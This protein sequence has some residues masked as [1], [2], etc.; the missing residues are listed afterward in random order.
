LV[1]GEE[2]SGR[3]YP[4]PGGCLEGAG[5]GYEEAAADFAKALRGNKSGARSA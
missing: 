1:G 4:H 5:G 3:P 2:L